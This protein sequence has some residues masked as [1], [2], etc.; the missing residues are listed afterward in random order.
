[1][2]CAA[3]RSGTA[4]PGFGVPSIRWSGARGDRGRGDGEHRAAGL[5]DDLIGHA[6]PGQAGEGRPGAAGQHD[7]VSGPCGCLPRDRVGHIAAPGVHDGGGGGRRAAG[8]GRQQG[9]FQHGR[10]LAGRLEVNLQGLR[11]GGSQV[12]TWT[13]RSTPVVP[14]QIRAAA[15][16][17]YAWPGELT[18]TRIRRNEEPPSPGCALVPGPAISRWSIVSITTSR[19]SAAWHTVPAGG[20]AAL[21]RSASDR[22]SPSSLVLLWLP[23]SSCRYR[24]KSNGLRSGQRLGGRRHCWPLSRAFRGW[25]PDSGGGSGEWSGTRLRCRRSQLWRLAGSRL[26]ECSNLCL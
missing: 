2:A 26:S 4:G 24:R 25:G 13:R 16:A 20:R 10:G 15:S 11:S 18:G 12:R 8:P 17:G 5:A 1:M 3:G 14:P 6:A 9:L 23:L 7:Q 21:A 22:W 19:G